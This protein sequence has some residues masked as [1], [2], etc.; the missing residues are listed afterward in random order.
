VQIAAAVE[1]FGKERM[2]PV[3]DAL[4]EEITYEEIRLVATHL[5]QRKEE[6]SGSGF[7]PRCSPG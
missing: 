5:R 6:K 1:Q 4:P 7:A 2:K 3:K